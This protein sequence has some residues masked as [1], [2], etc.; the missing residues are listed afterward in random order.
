VREWI[1]SM[2]ANMP[3]M[4]AKKHNPPGALAPCQNEGRNAALVNIAIIQ[5]TTTLR[6]RFTLRTMYSLIVIDA[7]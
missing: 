6:L 3:V 7:S 1:K 4:D 5:R 2:T